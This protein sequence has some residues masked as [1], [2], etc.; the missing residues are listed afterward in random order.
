MSTLCYMSVNM[1]AIEC[2]WWSIP[3]FRRT[4]LACHENATVVAYALCLIHGCEEFLV[5][6]DIA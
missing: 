4:I 2:I 6:G 3:R 1:N 5:Y